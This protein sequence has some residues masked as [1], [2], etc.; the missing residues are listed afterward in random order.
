MYP[1]DSVLTIVACGL[2]WFFSWVIDHHVVRQP[3]RIVARIVVLLYSL[4]I[5]VVV[6]RLIVTGPIFR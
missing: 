6:L 2:T 5:L 4:S 1:I 3:Y